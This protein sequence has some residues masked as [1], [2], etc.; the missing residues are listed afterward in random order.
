MPLIPKPLT[1]KLA[2]ALFIISSLLLYVL[3]LHWPK[4]SVVRYLFLHGS[5]TLFLLTIAIFLQL[6]PTLLGKTEHGHIPKWSYIIF[7]PFHC[8]VFLNLFILD[9]LVRRKWEMECDEVHDNWY[10]GGILSHR[11]LKT[12]YKS[13]KID[14]VI[15]MTNE[16]PRLPLENVDA[17]L[18]LPTWDGM[19]PSMQDF[20]RGIDFVKKHMH[21]EEGKKKKILI[22]CC[23]GRGRSTTMLVGCLV[24]LGIY[25]TWE[26]AF[27]AVKKKRPGAKLNNH[28][29]DALNLYF[30]GQQ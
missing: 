21:G 9:R 7:W 20:A 29:R 15:D 18:N 30:K 10:L 22:H 13:P 23:Y 17:Y 25:P 26:E 8:F 1:N 2:V 14:V 5:V 11:D 3:H 6:S 4:L 19:N 12:R 28:M 24:A 16:Q 27:E